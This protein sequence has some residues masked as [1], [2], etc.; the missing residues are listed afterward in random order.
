M[1]IFKKLFTAVKGGVNE[2]GE[3][4]VDAN[5]ILIFEQE[6]REAQEALAVAKRSLTEVMAKEMQTTRA[7]KALDGEIEK[8]EGYAGQALE[9]G[10]EPLAL[11]IAGKIAEFEQQKSEQQEVLA[12]FTASVAKLKQQ[13]KIAEKTIVENQR[14]LSMVKT[15]ESVQKATMAVND[16]IASGDSAMASAKQSLERIKQR[17]MDKQ[18]QMDAAQQLADESSDKSLHDKMRAAGIGEETAKGADILARIKAKQSK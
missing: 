11:E 16:N 4:I 9:K 13:V 14:Q 12:T 2:V 17:Q 6:I 10:E 8:H 18:D 5:A 15:T 7:I 3:S 1:S